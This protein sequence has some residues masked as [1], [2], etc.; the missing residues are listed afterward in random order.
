MSSEREWTGGEGGHHHLKQ[1]S[2]V[3][4]FLS[5]NVVNC[6]FLSFYHNEI[7]RCEEFYLLYRIFVKYFQIIK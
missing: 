2:F 3:N 6:T 7:Q 4:I 1:C 5:I